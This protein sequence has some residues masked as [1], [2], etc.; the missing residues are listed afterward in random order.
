VSIFKRLVVA[1]YARTPSAIRVRIVRYATPNFTAGVATL[2]VRD[3]GEVL[4]LRFTYRSGWGL[5][6][7]MLSRHEEPEQTARR[8]LREELGIEVDVP[9]P[10]RIEALAGKQTVTF[11]TLARV[12]EEQVAAMRVDPVEIAAIEWFPI[13][14]SPI[15][16]PEVAAFTE[17]D[18]QAVRAALTRP[19]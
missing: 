4:F 12:T 6:G 8:E 19:Y 1:V 17:A 14:S 13:S 18:R 11:F 10:Y 3:S 9:P 16:D 7:G 2:L 5:P 15:L